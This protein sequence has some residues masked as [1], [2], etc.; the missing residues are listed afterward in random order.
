MTVTSAAVGSVRVEIRAVTR[1]AFP[2]RPPDPDELAADE[3]HATYG[4]GAGPS[5]H[6]DPEEFA[7]LTQ[8]LG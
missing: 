1:E 5:H 8:E 7:R 2:M 6:Y 4:A 3:E